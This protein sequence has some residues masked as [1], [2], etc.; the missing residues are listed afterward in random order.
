MGTL[1][2]AADEWLELWNPTAS[3]VDLTGW[4]LVAEDGTPSIALAGSIPAGGFF[5]LE[6][7]D[8][9]SVPGVA[10]DQ[11]YTGDLGNG[12][13]TLILKDATAATIDTVVGDTGWVNIGGN[14]TTKE[15]AQRKSDN[16]WVTALGTPKA[17]TVE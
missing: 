2:S 12:G 1:V 6:R 14:N 13:E 16:T 5:L 7:T 4:T 11:I 15:T 8:D 3:S 17:A 10:A 9:T